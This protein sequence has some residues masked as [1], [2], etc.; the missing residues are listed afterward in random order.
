GDFFVDD[1]WRLCLHH[2]SG[3]L[4]AFAVESVPCATVCDPACHRVA[5]T[6]EY[7]YEYTNAAA[8]QQYTDANGYLHTNGYLHINL[9]AFAH[10]YP[11]CWWPTK[12]DQQPIA[13]GSRRSSAAVYAFTVSVHG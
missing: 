2:A 8:R 10:L 1:D 4:S 6:Y 5:C 11:C 13:T 12:R 9:D 7:A 3:D